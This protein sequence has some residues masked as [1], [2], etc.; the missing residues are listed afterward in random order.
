MSE[1]VYSELYTYVTQVQ[2]YCYSHSYKF[3]AKRQ[4]LPRIRFWFA[5][6]KLANMIVDDCNRKFGKPTSRAVQVNFLYIFMKTKKNHGIRWH[7]KSFK[8]VRFYKKNTNCFYLSLFLD[9]KKHVSEFFFP[10]F[11]QKIFKRIKDSNEMQ[12]MG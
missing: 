11:Q 9:E 5:N 10:I 1:R 4:V 12:F 2:I 6:S 8:P 3:T 7:I